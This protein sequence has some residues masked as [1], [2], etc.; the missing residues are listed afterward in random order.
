MFPPGTLPLFRQSSLRQGPQ[1]ASSLV[2]FPPVPRP[3]DRKSLDRGEVG[4]RHLFFAATR[5]CASALYFVQCRHETRTFDASSPRGPESLCWLS[6]KLAAA[7]RR[8]DH[9]RYGSAL[10]I[11]D[12]PSTNLARFAGTKTVSQARTFEASDKSVE[13]LGA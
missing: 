3:G 13:A 2:I 9:P 7:F 11:E 10:E 8:T 12:R 6:I 1:S 4:F 5:A